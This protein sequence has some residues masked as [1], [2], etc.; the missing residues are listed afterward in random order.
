M[1]ITRTDENGKI[2]LTLDGWLDMAGAPQLGEAVEAI[3]KADEIV[4]DFARVEYMASS[5]LRQVV[6]AHRKAQDLQ[7]GFSVIHTGTEVMSIFR[8]TGIDQKI[9]ILEK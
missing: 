5:G 8:M 6:A 3:E 9:N 1:I 4:L 2:T 7:A